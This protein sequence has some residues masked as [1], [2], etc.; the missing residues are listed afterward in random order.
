MRNPNGYGS[1]YKLSGNRRRPWIARKTT[2]WNIDGTQLYYTIGYFESRSKAM[3]ALAEYNKKPTVERS[4]ITLEELYSEWSQS[5]YEKISFKT[6]ETYKTAWNHLAQLENMRMRDIRK[7]H[8]QSV[9]DGMY[10][11]KLSRSSCQKVKILA[12]LLYKNA[13][14][15]D[16]VDKNYAE[17]IELP[18]ETKEKTQIF[19]DISIMGIAELAKTNEWANTIMILIYTGMR[20][21]ELLSLTKNNIDMKNMCIT[22]GNKT[23]AGK[24]RIIPIH[25]KIKEFIECWYNKSD[26]F[27]INKNKRKI[28]INYYRKYLFYPTLEKA[29][30]GRLTP[31]S[32]RHTFASLMAKANVDTVYIQQIIGHADYSTTAN[33]YTHLDIQELKKAIESI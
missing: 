26:L 17:L 29:N 9:I 27:L 25:S 33:I 31:H 28:S 23:E 6:V 2:G 5:K 13:M 7:S 16:I 4:N 10:K 1:I 18:S 20:I 24:N 21:G 30:V 14:A 19:S 12:G 32:T 3:A 11:N 8:M 15:D 22:S